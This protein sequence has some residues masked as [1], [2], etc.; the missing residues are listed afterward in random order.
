MMEKVFLLVAYLLTC[1]ESAFRSY[2]SGDFVIG[3]LLPI[4]N[5]PEC[6]NVNRESLP[7]VESVIYSI[8]TLNAD[9]KVLGNRTIGYDIKDTCSRPNLALQIAMNWTRSQQL[10]NCSS[11]ICSGKKVIGVIGPVTNEEITLTATVFGFYHFTQFVFMPVTRLLS[12]PKYFSTLVDMDLDTSEQADA[13]ASIAK[14]FRWTCVNIVGSDDM[15]GRGVVTSLRHQLKRKNVCIFAEETIRDSVSQAAEDAKRIVAKIKEKVLVKVTILLTSKIAASALFNEAKRRNLTAHVWIGDEDLTIYGSLTSKY[16]DVIDGSLGIGPPQ[17]DL[18]A[19]KNHVLS[20]SRGLSCCSWLESLAKENLS[21][22]SNNLHG[23]KELIDADMLSYGKHYYIKRAVYSIAHA[24]KDCTG[25]CFDNVS[26]FY[27]TQKLINL[28]YDYKREHLKLSGGHIQ[29]KKILI[30]NLQ[31][32][33]SSYN[34]VTVGK[35]ELTGKDWNLN[36]SDAAIQWPGAQRI[37]PYSG[38]SEQCP[39]GTFTYVSPLTCLWECLKCPSGTFSD[40]Y[41]SASCKKCPEGSIPNKDQTRCLVEELTYLQPVDTFAVIIL[42]A[43]TLGVALDVAVLVI[44]VRFHHTPV[45]RASNLGFS[46][47]TLILLLV[48]FVTPL[49]FIGRPGDLTCKVRTVLI[50]I[51]Y[52]SVSSFLLTKTKRLIQ[53]FSAF[54][55]NRFL[56]NYWYSFVAGSFILVQAVLCGIYLIYF[57]P[58]TIQVQVGDNA[59]LLHCSRDLPL[60]ITSFSYNCLL[61]ALCAVFAFKSRNLPETY[62]EA[63]HICF[64]MLSYMITWAIYFVGHYGNTAGNLRAAVPSVGI[65]LGAYAVLLFIFMPKIK[66]IFLEPEKNTKK[67]AMAETRKYSID[68]ANLKYYSGGARERRHTLAVLPP[69]H[70]ST[71]DPGSGAPQT[72]RSRFNSI[73]LRNADACMATSIKETDEESAETD[74][75]SVNGDNKPTVV[76]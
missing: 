11:R 23:D 65:L 66:V 15:Y 38:L 33:G 37:A 8:Q 24:L 56:S 63:K 54:D 47:F 39:P 62:S 10:K 55:K 4:T 5:P 16:G 28:E 18:Q 13:I 42:V 74:S 49:L 30:T 21:C 32:M 59:M 45:V 25:S 72:N 70:P 2:E 31:K 40:N 43:S 64:T 14:R 51:L 69:Y 27:V 67:A 7:L 73:I 20:I 36:I 60:D 6:T 58:K 76:M 61:A 48:W 22:Q 41:T 34:Y 19:F 68:V 75:V 52:T 44:F 29:G 12:N 57:P 1:G 46:L 35:F 17:G 26:P 50:P 53:I 9:K 71:A 3:V